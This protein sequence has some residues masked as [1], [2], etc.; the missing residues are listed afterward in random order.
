LFFTPLEVV[1]SSLILDCGRNL[2][3]V[4]WKVLLVVCWTADSDFRWPHREFQAADS[5]LSLK[6]LV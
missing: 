3:S 6:W 1:E 5:R 4:C 2:T